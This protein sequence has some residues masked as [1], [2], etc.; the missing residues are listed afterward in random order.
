[1]PCPFPGMDPYIER[2]EIWGDFHTRFITRL[3]DAIQPSLRPR[4]L[5]L[6]EDR[7]YVVRDDQSRKP[8]VA[9][10]RTPSRAPPRT[11]GTAVLDV[12]TPTI[13]EVYRDEIRE[14]LIKIVEPAAGNRLVTAIE[15]LSPTNKRAGAGRHSYMAKREQYVA[16]GANIIEIDLLRGGQ[17]TVLLDPSK[18]ESLKPWHYLVAVTR[19]PTLHEVYPVLLERR[20]PRIAVPL[21]YEDQDVPLDLQAVFSECW[22]VAAYPELLHYD[23]PPPGELSADEQHW[24]REQLTKAGFGKAS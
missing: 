23:G 21:A 18:L 10:V 12:D 22:N 14:P 2:P 1:M 9:V 8:D 24:C 11:G 20:L 5:A 6:L 15:V 17:P 13:F 16:A 7:L 19:W 4:Y 3:C